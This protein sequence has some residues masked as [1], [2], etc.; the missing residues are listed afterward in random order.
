MYDFSTPVF[1]AT[2]ERQNEVR[3]L[4]SLT[5]LL[6]K[7]AATRGPRRADIPYA[8]PPENYDEWETA[9]GRAIGHCQAR[10]DF[11]TEWIHNKDLAATDA[12]NAQA[13]S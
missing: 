12:G 4:A 6:R 7:T 10:I 9:V 8:V 2:S 1:N 3:R 13:A 11:L 5:G